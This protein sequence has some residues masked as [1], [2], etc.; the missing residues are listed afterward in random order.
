[1]SWCQ[2]VLTATSTAGAL[3]AIIVVCRRLSKRGKP[4]SQFRVLVT[5]FNDWRN[6]ETR[7][8]WTS[9]ENPSSRLIVG[10]AS[11]VPPIGRHGPLVKVLHGLSSCN[12]TLGNI[13]WSF[14]TLPTLWNVSSS[15]DYG[16]YDIVIHL[17]LGVYDNHTT[18]LVE[19]GAFNSCCAHPDA[20]GRLPPKKQLAELHPSVLDS[21]GVTKRVLTSLKSPVDARETPLMPCNFRVEVAAA[22]PQNSYICNETNWRALS[23]VREVGTG[24]NGR[25]RAAFFIHVPYAKDPKEYGPLAEAVAGVISHLAKGALED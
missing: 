22:R 12:P 1:M 19:D 11:D 13:E 14:M 6:V 24:V 17:G 7:G 18:I 23:A 21:E 8:V 2:K 5:G 16:F 9:D 10:E 20:S 25:L 15:L 3:V 4:P